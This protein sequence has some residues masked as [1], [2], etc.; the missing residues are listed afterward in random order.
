LCSV[1]LRLDALEGDIGIK[2]NKIRINEHIFANEIRLIGAKSEQ[3]G[4]VTRE[5]AL[6]L[7]REAGLDL[8]EISG[9]SHPPVC[10][11]MDFGKYRYEQQQKV[12][13]AKKK[14]KVIH[15]KEVKMTPKITEHDLDIKLDKIKRF[16]GEGDKVRVVVFFRGREG[17]HPELGQKIITKILETSKEYALVDKMPKSEENQISM[18][19]APL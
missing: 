15:V 3:I 10:K 19:L 14:Q 12:K 6:N 2:E 1:G 13:E 11:I 17:A 16:V 4:I 7:A 9:G 18:T 8:C 5:T